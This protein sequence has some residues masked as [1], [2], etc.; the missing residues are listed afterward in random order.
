QHRRT[1]RRP[2]LRAICMWHT[3]GMVRTTIYLPEQT[4][5]ALEAKARREGRTEAD[6]IRDALD[7]TLHLAPARP[8]APLFHS[9]QNDTSERVDEILAD[10]FGKL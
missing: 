10:G 6:I 5:R 3:G 2:S 7:R 4:K 9:G 8:W 1:Q